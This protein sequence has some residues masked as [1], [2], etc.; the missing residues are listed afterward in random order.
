[1]ANSGDKVKIIMLM[2]TAAIALVTE[3]ENK[4]MLDCNYPA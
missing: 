1:M 4:T 3:V 2:F